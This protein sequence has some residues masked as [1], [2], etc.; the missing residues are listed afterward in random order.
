MMSTEDK[1]RPLQNRRPDPFRPA[2]LKPV[3]QGYEPD[4][5]DHLSGEQIHDL[6]RPG[7]FRRFSPATMLAGALVAGAMAAGCDRS[8]GADGADAKPVRSTRTDARLKA[9]V[10][11]IVEEVLGR[12]KDQ[13]VPGIGAKMH[14]DSRLPSNPPVKRPTVE[15][16]FGTGLV[17]ILDTEAA[18][19]A[20]R[21]LF[22]AYGIELRP[23]V[24]ISGDGYEF[25]ADGYDPGRKVG[26]KLIVPDQRVRLADQQPVRGPAA[27]ALDET[28]LPALDRA[29]KGGEV[30]V[31][32]A[33]G[34]RFGLAYS[35]LTLM[36]Y[37]LASVVDYLN[38]VHGDRR[39]E[40][41]RVLGQLPEGHASRSWRR[42][43]PIPG[44]DFED[45][46]DPTRWAA[47]G[48]KISVTRDWSSFGERGLRVELEPGGQVTYTVPGNQGLPVRADDLGFSCCMYWP[49]RQGDDPHSVVT[50]TLTGENGKTVKFD[51]PLG[52]ETLPREPYGRAPA[53]PPFER[54]VQI[55]VTTNSRQPV[56]F[57]LDEVGLLPPL[58][59]PEN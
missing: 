42:S 35:E 6:L 21:K 19:K 29:I 14:L 8:A 36:Q 15:T 58:T 40:L 12:W 55:T 30:N 46:G 54:L 9:D 3:P 53:S 13:K 43:P 51:A 50:F 20:T 41:N 24:N 34:A 48:G 17:G 1:P 23:N 56:L 44:G 25:T 32:V 5:P 39:I 57:F 16:S 10:D 11:R 47:T 26:F 27:R 38:W 7:L 33:D 2:R 37:Y 18:K 22:A 49:G 28:E 4:Y 31:F 59:Q 45:D 52:T